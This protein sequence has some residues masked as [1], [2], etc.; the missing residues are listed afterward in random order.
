MQ[1]FK[2]K[3]TEISFPRQDMGTSAQREK[4]SSKRVTKC[5]TC[6]TLLGYSQQ[7]PNPKC[8]GPRRNPNY[9][10]RLPQMPIPVQL[11][12]GEREGHSSPNLLKDVPPGLHSRGLGDS[13]V[14][15]WKDSSYLDEVMHKCLIVSLGSAFL[16]AFLVEE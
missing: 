3:D 13:T 2:L 4:V 1:S 12:R 5:E 16:S 9:S 6:G 8:K 15:S 10:L 11:L 7:C 14:Q